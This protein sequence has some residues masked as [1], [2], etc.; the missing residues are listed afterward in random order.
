MPRRCLFE[1][2]EDDPL[3]STVFRTCVHFTPTPVGEPQA[4][5]STPIDAGLTTELVLGVY[6][7]TVAYIYNAVLDSLL[8]DLRLS[9]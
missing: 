7:K 9:K 8:K 3:N 2:S 4:F 1:P 6:E 5:S